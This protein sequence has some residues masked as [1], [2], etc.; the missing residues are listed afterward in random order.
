LNALYPE[1]EGFRMVIAHRATLKWIWAP[2]ILVL[3]FGLS[4]CA[5]VHRDTESSLPVAKVDRQVLRASDLRPEYEAYLEAN[6]DSADVLDWPGYLNWR[7]DCLLM[8]KEI[9]KRGLDA[10]PEF[11]Y[12][13]AAGRRVAAERILVDRELRDSL[14]E[15]EEEIRRHY[16]DHLSEYA[17]PKIVR[18]RQIMTDTR[19][20]AE[21]ARKRIEGG[22]DFEA[23]AR[24]VSIHPSR[25]D[26]GAL[27]PFARGTYNSGFEEKVFDLGVS[28]LSGVFQTNLGY[29]VAEKTAETPARVTP[30]DQVREEIRALLAARKRRA[31]ID[32]LCQRLREQ[33]DIDFFVP[34]PAGESSEPVKQDR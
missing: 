18:I 30:L 9:E 20:A 17:Q 22:E 27:P 4:A 26:G 13:S 5:P 2:V 11:T 33:A 34:E 14:A 3:G 21:L 23:V 24:E 31:A 1:S 16:E 8:E 7:I 10:D 29:H 15:S 12:L 28:E 32:G 19:E 6:K 25:S